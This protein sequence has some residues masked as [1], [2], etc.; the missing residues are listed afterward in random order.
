MHLVVFSRF[1]LMR[2]YFRI[3]VSC[4]ITQ[5]SDAGEAQTCGPLVSVKHST[6]EPLH[7]QFYDDAG[8]QLS[9]KYTYPW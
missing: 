5:S 1:L 6:T 3:N 8:L 7:S 2:Q 4:S 9:S